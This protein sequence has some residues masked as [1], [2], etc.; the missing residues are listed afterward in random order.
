VFGGTPITGVLELGGGIEFKLSKNFNIAL[1]EKVSITKSD[2]LDGQEWQETGSTAAHALTS[3]FD[4]YNF[5]SLG[6]NYN[7]GR[8]AVEPL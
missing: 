8:R 5:L 1:E 3:S 2:L 7:I 4:S 6:L